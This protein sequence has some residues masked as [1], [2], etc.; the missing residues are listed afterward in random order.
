MTKS[1]AQKAKALAV[2]KA[3]A[4]SNKTKGNKAGTVSKPQSSMGK[5]STTVSNS[6]STG[7]TF[8][9]PP[10]SASRISKESGTTFLTSIDVP[11]ET[12]TIGQVLH[13]FRITPEMGGDSDNR[14]FKIATSFQRIKYAN[15]NI[16]LAPSMG[17]SSGGSICMAFVADADDTYLDE[18]TEEVLVRH[19]T[20][21]SGSVTSNC[22]D[23]LQMNLSPRDYV[24]FRTWFYT[25]AGSEDSDPRLFS[26]GSVYVIAATRLP[27]GFLGLLRLSWSVELNGQSDEVSTEEGGVFETDCRC[28]MYTNHDLSADN[29]THAGVALNIPL[30]WWTDRDNVATWAVCFDV[31]GSF[32]I[33]VRP[34][35][36][37]I[38]VPVLVV[39]TSLHSTE[40]KTIKHHVLCPYALYVPLGGWAPGTSPAFHGD[41]FYLS[42]SG[43]FLHSWWNTTLNVVTTGL[44]AFLTS[45]A[46]MHSYSAEETDTLKHG[47]PPGIWTVADIYFGDLSEDF[48][49]CPSSSMGPPLNSSEMAKVPTLN[50]SPSH[51]EK[52]FLKWKAQQRKLRSITLK[53]YPTL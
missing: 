53:K 48:Q 46:E 43:S 4:S 21:M 23:K 29:S 8:R 27:E 12:T 2:K 18:M 39:Y 34:T 3:K 24:G 20:E 40:E 44:H 33:P 5:L 25:N 15:L 42:P 32:E 6:V 51:S 31:T 26:P 14:L 17:T 35:L 38:P 1:A 37:R 16:S 7:Y 52:Y 19:V 9:N 49:P 36:F 50:K 41:R 10:P 28:F 45:C 47:T 30:G 22:W 13:K 11:K